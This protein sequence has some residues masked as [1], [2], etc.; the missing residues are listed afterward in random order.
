MSSFRTRSRHVSDFYAHTHT[1]RVRERERGIERDTHTHTDVEGKRVHI[2]TRTRAPP[3]NLS[4]SAARSRDLLLH[5]VD[6][7]G[8]PRQLYVS[9]FLFS[10]PASKRQEARRFR[11]MFRA[12]IEES[13]PSIEL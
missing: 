10:E 7:D 13:K 5:G 4:I 3:E 1:L 8:S 6:G 11:A 12:V 9:K 2:R